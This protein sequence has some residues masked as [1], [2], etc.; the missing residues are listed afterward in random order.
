MGNTLYINGFDGGPGE[1]IE[2]TRRL[3]RLRLNGV[4]TILMKSHGEEYP[5]NITKRYNFLFPGEIDPLIDSLKET[6]YDEGLMKL[7]RLYSLAKS[8]L[9]IKKYRDNGS[10]TLTLETRP[11]E[12][13]SI[14][15]TLEELGKERE[16]RELDWFITTSINQPH[17]NPEK[18]VATPGVWRR[19]WNTITKPEKGALYLTRKG[20]LKI[21]KGADIDG[22]I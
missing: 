1:W 2:F 10:F 18:K 15:L 9:T 4:I 6:R 11:V 5:I 19:T 13:K 14:E 21:V 17:I 12:E 7:V 20:E 16:Y 8:E 3:E 22:A